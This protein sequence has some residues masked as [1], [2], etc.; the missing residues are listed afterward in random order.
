MTLK[1]TLTKLYQVKASKPP[2]SRTPFLDEARNGDEASERKLRIAL[3]NGITDQRDVRSLGTL[4]IAA[5]LANWS[6]ESD[7]VV[8]IALTPEE[9]ELQKRMRHHLPQ[10]KRYVKTKTIRRK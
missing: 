6:G 5:M 9:L 3:A 1:E 7:D 2:R 10:E 4:E 8:E